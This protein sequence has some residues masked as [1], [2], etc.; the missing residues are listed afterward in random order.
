MKLGV[1]RF[2]FKV[3][4][5]DSYIQG[6]AFH[7]GFS[8]AIGVFGTTGLNVDDNVVHHTVGEG[9]PD[10]SPGE[11]PRPLLH[12]P[13]SWCYSM[14]AGIR[15]WGDRITLRRNLVMMSLWPGSYQGREE[16]F[17]FQWNAAIEV[18]LKQTIGCWDV[19]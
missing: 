6:C 12:F 15:V 19:H 3:S 11:T 8:P 5:N 16:P 13:D 9:N 18:L 1:N 10:H 4:G 17:N 7:D 14:C 2:Y